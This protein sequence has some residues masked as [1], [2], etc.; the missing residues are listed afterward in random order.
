MDRGK[1]LC[2]EFCTWQTVEFNHFAT[3]GRKIHRCFPRLLPSKADLFQLAP[4][5]SDNVGSMSISLEVVQDSFF[6][7]SSS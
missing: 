3:D 6:I 7:S 5:L 4:T 1:I 2:C